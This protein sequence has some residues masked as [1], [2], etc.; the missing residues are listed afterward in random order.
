MKRKEFEQLLMAHVDGE[1]SAEDRRRL[2]AYIETDEQARTEFE[3]M[4]RLNEM[5]QAMSLHEPTE[6][7][8]RQFEQGLMHRLLY[9]P[10]HALGTIAFLLGV[11]L[12][13]GYG[14]Y[15]LISLLL[16]DTEIPGV[17]R[18]GLAAVVT[19]LL[20]MFANVVIRRLVT[21]PRDKYHHEVDK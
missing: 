7:T 13:A 17:V 1:I 11:L 4:Q 21:L 19:G 18:I 3:Q 20:A 9:R 6:A 12:L 5:E 15:Q 10:L 2:L 14:V 16:R 8:W